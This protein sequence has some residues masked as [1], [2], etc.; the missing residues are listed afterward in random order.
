MEIKAQRNNNIIVGQSRQHSSQERKE[1]EKIAKYKHGVV[2]MYPEKGP[3]EGGNLVTFIHSP[4]NASVQFSA[5]NYGGCK[6]G[7]S[8]VVQISGVT[9]CIFC[10]LFL[11]SFPLALLC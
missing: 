3:T 9:R 7:D 10:I 11:F 5:G 4:E 8:A 2:A 1:R 6:F